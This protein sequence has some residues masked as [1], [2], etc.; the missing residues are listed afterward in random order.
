MHDGNRGQSNVWA[1]VL[2]DGSDTGR[3]P[4][5]AVPYAV[6]A[7]HAVNATN[8]IGPQAQQV[9]PSGAVIFFNAAACPTGW[10]AMAGARGRYIVG[11]NGG[12]TLGA[13]VGTA[14]ADQENRPVGQHAH[15]VNDPGH[16][17][18]GATGGI[19]NW[20]GR[21]DPFFDYTSSGTSCTRA[22]PYQTIGGCDVSSQRTTTRF[23]PA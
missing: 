13:S 18:V 5:G 12:G 9:V 23:P 15:S 16:D 8:L 6:E 7:N 3:T 19:A 17:H 14:M 10:T 4:I 20:S 11:L 22:L 21:T 2:V 1:D